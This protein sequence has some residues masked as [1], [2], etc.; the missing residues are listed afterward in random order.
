MVLTPILIS[1]KTASVAILFTFV[2]GTALAYAVNRSAS[3]RL[4]AALDAVLTLPLVLPPTVAG[5]FLLYLFGVHRPLG[6]L[7]GAIGVKLV[8]S[9][10]ATVLAAVV[11]ALPLMYR[12][13]RAAFDQVDPI[14]LQAARTIGLPESKIAM[15]ILFPLAAP[16]LTSGGILSFSR[17]LGEFGATAMIAGNIAGVSRT[18]PLAIYSAVAGGRMEDAYEYVLILVIV[19]FLF[20]WSISIFSE[21][22]AGRYRLKER[23]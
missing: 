11:I 3:E 17:G 2:I 5:F 8:F 10:P 20:V 16:G 19:S 1:L 12:S 4:K 23:G 14:Y 21:T 18:M 22:R 9:W 6:V 13:A 7:L 15:K